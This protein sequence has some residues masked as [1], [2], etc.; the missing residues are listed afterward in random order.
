MKQ[1]IPAVFKQKIVLDRVV[2][3]QLSRQVVDFVEMKTL[4]AK[5]RLAKR[6]CEKLYFPSKFDGK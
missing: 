1:N 6:E 2:Q 5:Q 4:L 3:H